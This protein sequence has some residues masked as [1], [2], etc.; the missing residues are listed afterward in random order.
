MHLPVLQPARGYLPNPPPPPATALPTCS[1]VYDNYVPLITASI[2]FSAGLSLYLY[3]SRWAPCAAQKG[4]AGSGCR[5]GHRQVAWL[6]AALAVG[7]T[8]NAELRHYRLQSACS[9]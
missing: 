5:G 3:I 1:W 2:I 4:G 7:A 8:R 9:S 6:G